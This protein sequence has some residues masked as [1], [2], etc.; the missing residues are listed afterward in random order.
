MPSRT[1]SRITKAL[2]ILLGAIVL[3]S[4]LAAE[5]VVRTQEFAASNAGSLYHG[6]GNAVEFV[7]PGFFSTKMQPFNAS[8][9]TLQSFTVKWENISGTLSGTCG[10]GTGGNA[11]GSF[12]GTFMIEGSAYGGTG[13][14]QGGGN[15]P[16]LPVEVTF[17]AA[18]IV[19]NQTFNVGNAGVDY[20]PAI[21]AAVTGTKPF[22]VAFDSP[23]TVSYGNVINLAARVTAKVTLTYAYEAS[24][25]KPLGPGASGSRPKPP[26][27][28][29]GGNVKISGTLHRGLAAIGGETTGWK[30]K[31]H[32]A[33]GNAS[34]E[35]DMSAIKEAR[36]GEVTIA[37]QIRARQYVE[38]G[39]ILILKAE[40]VVV[41]VP[42]EKTP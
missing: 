15:G 27:I 34:I 21:L 36:E 29:A 10:A 14:G 31:Y 25:V 23:V 8:L 12:G 38:R 35:V 41:A 16:R 17:P 7:S 33:K 11:S 28:K 4:S 26:V 18:P 30:L 37:G 24:G 19:S 22:L 20:D 32:G 3:A 39:R 2:S 42:S 1:S 6:D 13:G 40:A 5:T 9:G